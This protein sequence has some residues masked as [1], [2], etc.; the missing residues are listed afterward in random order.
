MKAIPNKVV[1]FAGDLGATFN[2]DHY[3]Y[4]QEENVTFIGSGMGGG[5]EDN[6]IIVEVDEQHVPRFK[7]IGI[8]STPPEV[9][10]YIEGYKLP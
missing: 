4:Y 1:V 2:V 3:M 6:I 5:T 7:K 9:I 8:N 10:E